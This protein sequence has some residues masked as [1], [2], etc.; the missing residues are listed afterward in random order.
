LIAKPTF[1]QFIIGSVLLVYIAVQI[2]CINQLSPNYD[3]GSFAAYGTTLLKFQREKDIVAFESKLPITALNMIPRAIQQILDPGLTKGWPDSQSDIIHGRYVSLLFSVLI[4]LLIFSWASKLYNEKTAFVVLLTY[5]VCPN[6]LAH[7]IFVSSDIFACFFMA[8]TFYCLWLF[9]RKGNFKYYLLM[10]IATGF[11]EI[12]KFS[13]F[14]LLLLVPSLVAAQFFWQRVPGTTRISRIKNFSGYIA[15][16][17]GINWIVICSAHL[18]YQVFL[19]I[20][21]YH[22]KSNSFNVLQN[23]FNNTLPQFPVPLPSSYIQ[24]LDAVIYFDCL[25]GGVKGS[26]NGAPYILGNSSIHGFWYYY[27]VVI[28]FKVPISVLVLWLAAVV[29]LIASFRRNAFFRNEIF[30][31]LPIGYYLIYMSCFYSTQLGIR[32]LLIIFPL[33]FI[34]SGKVISQVLPG[35]WRWIIFISVGYQA[36]SVFSY[37][38]HFLPYTNEFILNKKMAYKKIADSN[39]CYGEGGKFLKQYLV[40]HP[41]VIYL[42]RKPT[43]GTAILEVNEMLN[44][45]IASVHKYDWARHLTPIDHIHSQ[46]LIF[47]VKKESL[48]SIRSTF[49]YE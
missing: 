20:S 39:L 48:D 7:G 8:A 13:M 19:P 47:N 14:H 35:K 45:D 38:P 29:S 32:H 22:F 27:L 28:F 25:G 9:F 46:Y 37:F 12:S 36:I 43:L 15:I 2:Y 16:F 34:F 26:L 3:E 17:I 31:L 4:G 10:C 33:L 40:T 44:L 41:G 24:S 18:F 5:L 11:A 21:G 6:F 49:N 1:N 42:P 30:L 23:F